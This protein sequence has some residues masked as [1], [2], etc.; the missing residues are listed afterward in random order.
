[1]RVAF[2]PLCSAGHRGQDTS[3][4]VAFVFVLRLCLR[5]PESGKRRAGLARG[6]ARR[7]KELGRDLRG[8]ACNLVA[9]DIVIG[10]T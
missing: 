7:H 5:F 10:L 2:A 9:I 4:C 8:K 1:M 6:C 3:K